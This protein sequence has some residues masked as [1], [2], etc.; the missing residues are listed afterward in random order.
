M[1]EF[2][3]T[4]PSGVQVMQLGTTTVGNN[5]LKLS[6]SAKATSNE[7]VAAWIKTLEADSNFAGVELGSVN[8]AGPNSRTF[9][10]LATYTLKL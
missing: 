6:I 4:V 10:V 2:A 7:S 8:A 5:G 3:R 9:T 1:S